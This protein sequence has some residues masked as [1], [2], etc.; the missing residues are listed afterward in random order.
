MEMMIFLPKIT[1]RLY[2]IFELLF[3]E[4]LGIDFKFTTDKEKFLLYEGPKFHYD[5]YPLEEEPGLY[6]QSVKLLFERDIY[7]QDLKI[8]S[9]GESKA[10]YQVFNEKSMLP[11]DIFAASFYIISRYEEY[12]PHV[13]DNYS[14]FQPQD[15][16]LYKMEMIE[17]PVINIW[18]KEL[19]ELVTARYPEINLKKKTFRFVPTYDIDAA[20]AYKNKGLFRTTFA[21]FRD[22]MRFDKKEIK[23]RWEVL[24]NKKIDPFDTFDYQIELQKELKIK[25]LYFILCGDYNTND[26][27]ISIKN[28]EFQ[29]LIKHIGDYA[30]VGIHPSFNSYLKKNVI[31]EEIRRLSDVLKRE[32]TM[33]RQ[34][35]LRLS[36]PSSYQILIELDITDDYT[37]GYAS[38]A[39][40]RAGYADTFQFFDLE[41]DMKTKLN[42]H[43]FALMDGTMRDYLD[44]DVHESYEKAKSLIDE[45]KNVNGTFILLWHNETLSGEKRW[46][47][48]ITLYRKILDYI[49]N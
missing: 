35:F 2:Y 18:A 12:L 11:F 9:Y 20:W 24:R 4:E 13:S 46:E 21:F 28:K 6:Q 8:F 1:N 43:P 15:S 44:L 39:G 42:I 23:E 5:K 29:Q 17:K 34:H 3:K 38:Q 7:D 36:L 41:N 48:W 31:K 30:L 10:I 27:N 26:K 16:I 19:G 47:G 49:L 25:P 45:V 40:F 33:S 22:V 37:M 32:V 14:R